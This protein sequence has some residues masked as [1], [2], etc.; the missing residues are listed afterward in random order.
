MFDLEDDNSFTCS[1]LDKA[2]IEDLSI[3]DKMKSENDSF[4]VIRQRNGYHIWAA[5]GKRKGMFVCANLDQTY[6]FLENN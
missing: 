3:G 6:Q 4:V 5:E 1:V 2:R